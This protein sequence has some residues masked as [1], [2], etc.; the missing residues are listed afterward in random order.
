MDGSEN[1]TQPDGFRPEGSASRSGMPVN[2]QLMVLVGVLAIM[3]VVGG[4]SAYLAHDK[5]IPD[6]QEVIPTHVVEHSNN[7]T[8]GTR[9]SDINLLAESALVMDA[10]SGE[11]LYE[12]EPDT[13]R[14]LASITKL[15]TALVAK[16]IVAEGAVIPI[17][18]AA[19]EQSGDNQ[20]RAG[21]K[22]SYKKLSDLMLLVSSNDGAYA[23]SS[24]AGALLD[25]DTPETAF[26][27]AMNVRARELG[28]SFTT[29]RNPTG[30]DIS[31]SEAGAYG[32]AREVAKL[33]SYIL[34][35]YP[36]LLE[37][38]TRSDAVIGNEDGEVHAVHNTNLVVD[39][40]AKVIGSKTGYTTLA[41]GNLVTAFD[42][43]LDR[44]MVA[45]VLGSSYQGRFSD[46]VKLV[47]AT[48][49]E[50]NSQNQ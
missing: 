23:L 15:M 45:V 11:I 27:K 35:N 6:Q 41:G 8:D 29:F 21:E 50:I 14:P 40:I 26:V 16:E 42:V 3:F 9:F 43:G 49:N 10:R 33:A 31:E 22:F 12:K 44:P 4:T 28:L 32:T 2:K 24:A 1:T 36:D 48:L 25:P 17:T 5:K 19:L 20:L 18:A 30:L 7:D 37:S 47:Q 13:R 46:M 34:A 39:E 38:T